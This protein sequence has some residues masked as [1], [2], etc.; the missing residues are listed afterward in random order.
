MQRGSVAAALGSDLPIDVRIMAA[1]NRNL[2][3]E[4][5]AGRF[6]EDL[7]FRL[8]VISLTLPSLRE[9]REDIEELA[10]SYLEHFRVRMKCDVKTISPDAVSALMRYV[11]PGNL[12]EFINAIERA[13]IMTTYSARRA[14][15]PTRVDT[16]SRRRASTR[17]R[18]ATRVLRWWGRRD[19][20]KP[21]AWLD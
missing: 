1:T 19:C 17:R 21:S 2:E 14:P 8:N 18:P 3:A 6:R 20:D 9:R 5:K 10:Q 16:G 12:R 4:V 11:W 13:V 15:P 7:Y